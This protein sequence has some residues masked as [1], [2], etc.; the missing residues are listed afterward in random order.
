[1]QTGS[2]RLVTLLAIIALLLSGVAIY[3]QET[4]GGLQGTV[5]DATGAV[6]G[7]AHVIVR[8]TAL[9]GDISSVMPVWPSS[10]GNG[11]RLNVPS[12]TFMTNSK[13]SSVAAAPAAPG[14]AACVMWEKPA[15]S[16]T[17]KT[18]SAVPARIATPAQTTS[19]KFAAGPASAIHAARRG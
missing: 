3:A 5:K 6:V 13:L 16:G 9:A 19:V 4:T 18:P 11:R 14:T 8:G 15:Y 7:G 17:R 2:F 10:G 12:R 1:M